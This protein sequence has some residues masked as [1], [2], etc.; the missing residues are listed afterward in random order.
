[1]K[2]IIKFVK[3]NNAF[4]AIPRSF[5]QTLSQ[6]LASREIASVLRLR[7]P[8][9]REIYVSFNGLFS[10]NEQD[11]E[12]SHVFA[13][14]NGLCEGDFVEVEGVAQSNFLEK[15][16]FYCEELDYEVIC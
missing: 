15:F 1:M 10:E 5:A 6:S 4:V 13:G 2:L 8:E 16:D 7:T 11:L 12:I 14:L 3:R 9:K